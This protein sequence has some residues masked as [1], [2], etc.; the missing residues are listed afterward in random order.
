MQNKDFVAALT[1][2]SIFVSWLIITII[3]KI[4]ENWKTYQTI[5]KK[6]KNKG[7][8]VEVIEENFKDGSNSKKFY[9]REEKGSFYIK[10]FIVT[11]NETQKFKEIINFIKTYEKDTDDSDDLSVNT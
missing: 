2:F 3:Y 7:L 5:F 8:F 10:S 6:A 4:R 11:N 1:F 9:I